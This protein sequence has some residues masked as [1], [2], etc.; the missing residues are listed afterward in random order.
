MPDQPKFLLFDG[1]AKVGLLDRAMVLD[2]ADTEEEAR[3]ELA[4]GGTWEDQDAIWAEV[5]PNDASIEDEH[6]RWDLLP[7][8][9]RD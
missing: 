9:K 3:A 1:R 5:P 2:T 4:P 6:L 8:A 7:G